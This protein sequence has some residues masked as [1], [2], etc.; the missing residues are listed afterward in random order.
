MVDNSPTAETKDHAD[1]AR[2]TAAAAAQADYANLF[3][4]GATSLG[5]PLRLLLTTGYHW[6]LT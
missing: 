4:E 1:C 2:A 5:A 6:P 3:A